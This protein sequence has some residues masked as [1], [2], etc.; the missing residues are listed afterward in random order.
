MC[1]AEHQRRKANIS[2]NQLQTLW[3]IIIVLARYAHCCNSGMS[4]TGVTK[5]FVVEFKTYSMR[6]NPYLAVVGAKSL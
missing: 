1:H 2:L 4:I 3:A 6:W 5:C